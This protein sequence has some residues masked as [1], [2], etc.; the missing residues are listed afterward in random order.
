MVILRGSVS[1]VLVSLLRDWC[2]TCGEQNTS[3]WVESTGLFLVTIENRLEAS[4]CICG[5]RTHKLQTN[6]FKP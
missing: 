2:V 5:C 4:I 1:T 3:A 6:L